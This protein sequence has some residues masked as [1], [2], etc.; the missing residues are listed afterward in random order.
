MHSQQCW[1]RDHASSLTFPGV[2]Y[3]SDTLQMY[4]SHGRAVGGQKHT[5]FIEREKEDCEH[6]KSSEIHSEQTGNASS[7]K[8]VISSQSGAFGGSS[9]SLPCSC[10]CVSAGEPLSSRIHRLAFVREV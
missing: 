1:Q 4:G 9:G 10:V 5:L 8:C 2:I 7:Q 3:S 6:R